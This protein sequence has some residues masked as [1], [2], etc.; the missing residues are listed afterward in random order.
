[1][2]GESVGIGTVTYGP[3]APVGVANG[4]GSGDGTAVGAPSG[5]TALPELTVTVALG[6]WP[7]SAPISIR[8]PAFVGMFV[9]PLGG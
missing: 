6:Y 9:E 7:L 2:F 5:T 4:V 8:T 1:M 3:C